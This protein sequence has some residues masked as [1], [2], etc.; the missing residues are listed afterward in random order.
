MAVKKTAGKS[1]AKKVAKKVVKKA[2]AKK[3]V[4]KPVAKKAVKKVAKKTVAKKVVK[5]PVAKKVVKKPVAKKVVKKVA[6]KAA[7]KTTSTTKSSKKDTK[8]VAKKSPAKPRGKTPTAKPAAKKAASKPEAKKATPAKVAIP[9]EK[10]KDVKSPL[11]EDDSD[12]QPVKRGRK[13][14]YAPDEIPEPIPLDHQGAIEF[15]QA[16]KQPD[17]K[18]RE[19]E[20]VQDDDSM[21]TGAELKAMRKVFEADLIER[22]EDLAIAQRVLTELIE[23]TDDGAGAETADTGNMTLEREMQISKVDL[24]QMKVEETQLAL[25]RLESKVFGLCEECGKPIGKLRLQE[26]NPYATMCI[27]CKEAA[28]KAAL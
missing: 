25:L 6:K 22:R 23:N 10:T 13:Y 15:S 16:I 3:A 1:V 19:K 24:A 17:S 28:D 4:K 21:W 18:P 11:I 2:T 7:P 8:K 12:K 26:A 27:R 20:R 5:K 9:K 14:I